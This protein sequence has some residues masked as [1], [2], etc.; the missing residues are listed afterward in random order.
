VK[1]KQP[2]PEIAWVSEIPPE[3]PY[4]RVLSPKPG[5]PVNGM[6]LSPATVS[7]ITHYVDGRTRPCTGDERH[8]EGCLRGLSQRPKAY[9]AVVDLSNNQYALAELTAECMRRTPSLSAPK[10][11]LRGMLLKLVR[12]GRNA[13]S[14]VRAELSVTVVPQELPS[15]PDVREALKRIWFGM[16]KRKPGLA[17]DQG[18]ASPPAGQ[19][20]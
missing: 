2:E 15:E 20:E 6:I 1:P 3:L 16:R 5:S 8:C 14:R 18:G 19:A 12:T 13:N 17:G 9:L 4:L 7:V 10:R 11:S